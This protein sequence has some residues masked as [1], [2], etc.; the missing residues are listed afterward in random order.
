MMRGTKRDAIGATIVAAPG[1][2]DDV[3]V[4]QVAARPARR[5]AAPPAVA[6]KHRIVMA[7]PRV[8]FGANV[9][10]EPLEPPPAR[11]AASREG[12]D[13]RLEERGNR[14]RCR[15]ADHDLRR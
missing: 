3:V 5:D 10:E 13:R 14:R 8:P 1:A 4:V 6:S 9:L 7:R 2:K 12:R 11:L 15:N